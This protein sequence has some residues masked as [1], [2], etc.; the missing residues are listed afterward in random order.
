MDSEQ[1][2]LG[3][4]MKPFSWPEILSCILML[5]LAASSFVESDSGK[6]VEGPWIS[7]MPAFSAFC[8]GAILLRGWL[9]LCGIILALVDLS[10]LSLL[11]GKV[12]R[13]CLLAFLLAIFQA[14]GKTRKSLDL[15]GI[16]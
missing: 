16:K 12:T 5:V 10:L 9:V 11:M 14:A 15:K 6:L 7:F 2:R 4:E 13:G 3:K 8:A 1:N